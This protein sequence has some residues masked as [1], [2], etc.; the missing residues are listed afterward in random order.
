LAVAVG[1][2]FSPF[3]RARIVAESRR[4]GLQITF[5]SVRPGWFAVRL[6]GVKGR[7]VGVEGLEADFAEV[8]VGVSAWLTPREV[9]LTD[10]RIAAIGDIERLRAQ[11]EAWRAARRQ[12]SKGEGIGP[13]LR[14]EHATL[15]W[16]DGPTAFEAEGLELARDDTGL[17]ARIAR[18]TLRRDT[19]TLSTA[20]AALEFDASNRLS[21]AHIGTAEVG[22]ST[23]ERRG[24]DEASATSVLADLA[25]PPLPTPV[26]TGRPK[27]HKPPSARDDPPSAE[28]SAPLVALPDLHALRASAASVATILAKRLP[29]GSVV[30]VDGLAFRLQRGME[31]RLSLGP[32]PLQVERGPSSID[33]TFSTAAGAGGTPMSVHARL[34]SG[35]GDVEVS[36]SGG[37]VSL[38]LL[39]LHAR[40]LADVD[41]SMIAGKGRVVL[42]GRGN[43]LTFDVDLTLRGLAAEDP[44]LAAE[45]LRGLDFD[46]RARG[47]L[48]NQGELRLDDAEAAMGALH[49]QAH[50]SLQQAADHVALAVDLELPPNSCDAIFGSI[51][52]ALLPTLR[53]AHMAGTL[54]AQGRLAFDTRALD[55]LALEYSVED[56]CRMV[57]VPAELERE[58]FTKP[59]VHRI[60]TPDGKLAEE[61]TGPETDQWT[62]LDRVSP[63]MQAAILTTED[64]AFFHHHGF[65]HVAIRNALLADLKARRF[66]RG[67]STVTMQLAKN[68]F[69]SRDKSLSRK[70]EELILTDYL[71]QTFTKD[72]MMELYLNV[73]EFG[74]SVYGI[75]AAAEHYFGRPPDQLNLAECMFLSSILPKPVRYHYLYERGE[76]PDS[77]LRGIRARMIIAHRTGKITD[78][79]LAEG[80]GEPVVFCLPNMPRPPSRP[81]VTAARLEEDPREW[82]E[83]N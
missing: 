29:D 46:V 11:I 19:V 40:T 76:L 42:E 24:S 66:V 52:T 51:P 62:P 3:V 2:G 63:F 27:G 83:L 79:E 14:A 53:G 31:D 21:R 17:R 47:V 60:Y 59:F 81:A 25:P 15:Q 13:M 41:R 49:V 34:P 70:L 74:P 58:R 72:E 32:G 9:V 48:S 10:G 8:T 7:L 43:S 16:N 26:R 4:R 68:L 57:G 22:W 28:A 44:R 30:T 36:L 73:I 67:A 82:R 65:N 45:V 35:D 18:A 78:G 37:P 80:L 61:L 71:E 54:A 77:W 55:D 12:G 1:L 6:A 64:G 5:D 23:L 38:A 69:L 56:Q 33:M 50:G 39:G 20:D 75:T